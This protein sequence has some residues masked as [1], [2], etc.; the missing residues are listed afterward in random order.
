MSNFHAP[1]FHPITGVI[2]KAEWLD[3]HYGKHLYGVRFPD[4]HVCRSYQCEQVGP[5][6]YAEIERLRAY[7]EALERVGRA[8]I[9][10]DERGQGVGWQEA[11]EELHEILPDGEDK[12]N[13]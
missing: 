4:G 12:R 9:Y 8:L 11:M 6:A 7:I 2:E 3:D 1:T 13:P 10:H 5:K